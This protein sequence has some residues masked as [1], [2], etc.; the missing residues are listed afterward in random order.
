MSQCS[1]D[2]GFRDSFLPVSFCS[3]ILLVVRLWTGSDGRGP[4]AG[5]MN[6]PLKIWVVYKWGGGRILCWAEQLSGSEE[7]PWNLDEVVTLLVT[8]RCWI[9]SSAETS[10]VATEFFY[11]FLQYFPENYRTAP[12][13][14]LRPL[15]SM[16]IAFYLFMYPPLIQVHLVVSLRM[17]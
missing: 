6:M 16:Y 10:N 9:R 11:G 2:C 8:T 5:L 3:F 12:H 1:R 17:N 14:R 4:L 15:S 13:V 7:G